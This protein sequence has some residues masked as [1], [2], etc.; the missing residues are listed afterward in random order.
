MVKQ[1]NRP[2]VFVLASLCAAFVVTGCGGSSAPPAHV[3][4][5]SV[6][7]P[8]Y[9]SVVGVR[10][11]EVV[12]S[13]TPHGAK[14]QVNHA[15]AKVVR[16]SFK[17]GLTLRRG[18]N[19]IRIVATAHGY[20]RVATMVKL[21]YGPDNSGAA[22]NNF[23]AKSNGAC[24]KLV[25]GV[26]RL[27]QVTSAAALHQDV[28]SVLGLD[29]TFLAQLR[30]I[31]AP[32][33]LAAPF[34]QSIDKLQAA[35]NDFQTTIEEIQAGDAKAALGHYKRAARLANSGSNELNAIGVQECNAVVVPGG[36]G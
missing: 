9:G 28:E 18:V 35:V 8:N 10:D 33:K 30:A 24:S 20:K 34:R 7:A 25:A 12:G 32:G 15:R 22:L 17:H 13:V 2:L 6:V 5:L 36:G 23:L 19:H 4:T 11:I 14:V 3:I 27:P 21:S 16:G 31:H 29:Q 26:G 1:R